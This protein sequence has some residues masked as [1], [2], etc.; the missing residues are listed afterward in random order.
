MISAEKATG[1]PVSVAC[2]LLGVSRSAFYEW[3]RG[4]PSDRELADAWLIERITK[5]HAAH[6]GV[7]G[8]RRVHAELRI[9]HEVRVSGKRCGD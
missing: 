6:R 1:F 4:A 9:A 5:I 3:D 2:R 8:W 7:Y